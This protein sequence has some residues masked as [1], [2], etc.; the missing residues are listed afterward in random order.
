L[1]A[2]EISANVSPAAAENHVQPKNLR[3]AL[4][5]THPDTKQPV[6]APPQPV[7]PGAK[8]KAGFLAAA[9]LAILSL[10]VLATGLALLRAFR[11]R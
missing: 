11:Q 1:S 4:A 7:E 6:P 2:F 9:G 5:Q 10:L 8:R 3:L